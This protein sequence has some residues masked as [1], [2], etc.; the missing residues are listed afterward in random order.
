MYAGIV[1]LEDGDFD[2]LIFEVAF[3]LGEVEGGVV[4]RCVPVHY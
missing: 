4:W 1:G 3:A 2:V